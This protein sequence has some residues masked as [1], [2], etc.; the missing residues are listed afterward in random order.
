LKTLYRVTIAVSFGV[1][2]GLGGTVAVE[3]RLPTSPM[4]RG[5][6]VGGQELP[7][8]H[9]PYALLE[10]RDES[11]RGRKVTLVHGDQRFTVTLGEI[12]AAI[13][14]PA[15]VQRARA[16]GH[17]GSVLKRL[18]ETDE[19]RHGGIDVSLIYRFDEAV[20]RG[21]LTSIAPSFVTKPVDARLD[22]ENHRKIPDVKGQSLDVDASVAALSAAVSSASV[23]SEISLVTAET[24][25][26]TTLADLDHLDLSKVLGTYE[27]RYK[28]YKKGRS[29]NVEH[30]AKKLNGL[31]L[32]PGQTFSFNDRVGPRT[33]EAGF[34]RAPEIVGDELTIGIGGGT[35]QVSST[36]YAAAQFGGM[37]I[38]KRR[39][40]SRPSGYTKLGL[41]ATV[42]YP[43]VDLQIQNPYAYSVV[44]HAFVPEPGKLVVEVLGGEEVDHV[45][46]SY[47]ISSIEK[48]ERRIVEKSWY[49]DGKVYRKQKGT[50]GMDVFSVITIHYK[51]G[52]TEKRQTYSG[53][54]ATPEIYW[55]APGTTPG[56]LPD[57][58]SHA[59]GV[60]GQD[61]EEVAT[62][63]DIYANAG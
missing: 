46:Y 31:V 21:Y 57:L 39:S 40:H 50:R 33:V 49:K 1:V 44:I 19:A 55:V 56:E 11:Y 23:A 24:D 17:R 4:L 52:R 5:L 3:P 2:L 35:C 61:A 45:E 54:R 28:V 27:T 9:D 43:K 14:V 25:A 51:S 58:P 48:Y 29:H 12:G 15:T 8:G 47:G 38:I 60:E 37:K 13:D 34:D 30:A 26:E 18:R 6:K 53:Y 63:D 16:V 62:G 20:A 10:Q 22:L 41:D 42:S 7:E 59:K 32:R 36:L